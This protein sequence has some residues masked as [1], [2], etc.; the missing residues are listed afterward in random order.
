MEEI[1]GLIIDNPNIVLMVV[2]ALILYIII[3]LAVNSSNLRKLKLRFSDELNSEKDYRNH[4]LLTLNKKFKNDLKALNEKNTT[5]Y[6]KLE[7]I[8]KKISE[9]VSDEE[10]AKIDAIAAETEYWVTQYISEAG[11]EKKAFY[12]A[13]VL[14]AEKL[15]KLVGSLTLIDRCLFDLYSKYGC[16]KPTEG[17]VNMTENSQNTYDIKQIFNHIIKLKG[18]FDDLLMETRIISRGQKFAFPEEMVKYIN[19]WKLHKRGNIFKMTDD[20]IDTMHQ[21]YANDVSS[22]VMQFYGWDKEDID[23]H[24]VSTSFITRHKEFK[25][26]ILER[27]GFTGV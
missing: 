17:P 26:K 18:K 24:L 6:K 4:D 22:L 15:P 5:E 27:K 11:T 19:G 16:A 21:L 3:I 9:K 23:E 12:N 20:E 8:Y 14:R 7:S 1:T 13:V 10:R 2:G 25:E